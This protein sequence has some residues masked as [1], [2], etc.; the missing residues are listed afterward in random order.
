MLLTNESKLNSQTLDAIS[1][2]F[3]LLY[4]IDKNFNN[5]FC[6]FTTYIEVL[7]FL[8]TENIEK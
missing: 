3:M 1:Y 6:V 8:N 7:L 5:I 4:R 2:T